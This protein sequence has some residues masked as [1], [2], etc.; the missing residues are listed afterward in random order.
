MARD[1][2]ALWTDR[3]FLTEIQYRTDANLAARQS[4]YSYQQP[5]LDLARLVIDLADLAGPE[6]VVDVGCG[7]G[8]Y[9]AELARRQ[10]AG[11]VAGLD[12]SPG[13]L[14]AARGR[15]PRSR[16]LVGDAAAMPMRNA[17]CDITIAMHMLYH[18]PDPADAVRELRRITR[19]GGRVLIGLNAD[20]H[21]RELRQPV[22]AVLREMTPGGPAPAV[23][24]RL[25]LER[26][27]DLLAPY[28]GSVTRHDFAGELLLPGPEA[29]A[30]YLRSMF[31][32]QPLAEP[33]DFVAAV[34]SRIQAGL[35]GLFRVRTHSGCLVCS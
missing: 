27:M 26:G 4:I 15:A 18:V 32:V 14:Q 28:F 24:E 6:S 33:E 34:L 25:S 20:D 10:H 11:P 16:L 7:N 22:T 35:D 9:L 30:D 8:R 29:A 23:A 3:P 5:P 1:D 17:S 2:L 31:V 19:P 13:M 12:L 21:L